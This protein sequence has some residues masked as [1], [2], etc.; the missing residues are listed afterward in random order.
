[1]AAAVQ[2]KIGSGITAQVINGLDKKQ[3]RLLSS[4]AKS[5]KPEGQLI[6]VM[7]CEGGCI[8]GPCSH[9]FPKDAKRFFIQNTEK[10]CS[11]ES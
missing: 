5:K 8:S 11:C 1:V 6:E 9:E 4:Y 7:S 2:S 3:M 10:I